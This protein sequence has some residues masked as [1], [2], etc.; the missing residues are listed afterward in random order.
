VV[1]AMQ[2]ERATPEIEGG[3]ERAERL[4][5]LLTLS[6]E[7]MLAWRLGGPID[8][9]N[10]GA[11]RLYGYSS[12]EAI[13]HNSH[14]L[15]QTKF[16]VEFSEL[17]SQLQNTH[18]WSGELR[19]ICK[20][21]REVTVDSR[22]QLLDSDTV[23]EVNRDITH[24]KAIEAELQKSQEQLLFLGSIVESSDDAIVTKNLDGIITSWNRGAER[25]LATLRRR[26]SVSPLRS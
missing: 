3:V 6:F 10:S 24:H 7:P 26:R 21:G 15:L 25:I 20:D 22:M 19:H 16:P 2:I 8:L 23:L 12:G 18:Q 4:A 9:W 14:A 13:G 5:R 1:K 11:E 17:R